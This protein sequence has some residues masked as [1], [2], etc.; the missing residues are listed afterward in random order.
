MM[1]DGLVLTFQ[2]WDIYISMSQSPSC[3]ICIMLNVVCVGLS[4]RV[5]NVLELLSCSA[6][7]GSTRLC[8][9]T[10][11]VPLAVP[12]NELSLW[13]CVWLDGIEA[14]E[15]LWQHTIEQQARRHRDNGRQ[16]PW[17][18]YVVFTQAHTEHLGPTFSIASTLNIM[19]VLDHCRPV[20]FQFETKR[21]FN[22]QSMETWCN[23][24]RWRLA[25]IWCC[26]C[27]VELF[28]S[29]ILLRHFSGTQINNREHRAVYLHL[30]FICSS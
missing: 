7:W 23:F 16:E 2:L 6:V 20:K 9:P 14:A 24:V 18:L 19:S 17:V 30:Q 5:C 28:K 13:L 29:N 8:L 22:M 26:V 4:S 21:S 10:P 12:H 11:T 27:R 3:V 25:N 1:R 15:E